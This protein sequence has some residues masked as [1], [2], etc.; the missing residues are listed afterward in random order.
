MIGP[1]FRYEMVASGRKKRYTALRVVIGLFLLFALTACYFAAIEASEYLSGGTGERGL[2]IAARSQLAVSFFGSFAWLTL[3]GVLAAT[4]ALAA[5]AI[6]TERERR[7]IEYL[8]ATDLSN[9]EIV[10]DKIMSRLMIIAQI[11][12]STLPLLAIFMLLGG[13]P[14]DLLLIHFCCLASTALCVA[15]LS[16]MV[17]TWSERAREAV[18]QAYGLLFGC[19]IAPGILMALD[20]A[21]IDRYLPFVS[22]WFFWPVIKVLLALNPIAVLTESMSGGALGVGLNLTNV[23]IMIAGHVGVSVGCLG[24]C[25]HA[26]RKVHL[27]QAGS[28]PAPE[29]SHGRKGRIRSPYARRP[30]LWKEMFADSSTPKKKR[31]RTRVGA[32]IVFLAVGSLVAWQFFSALVNPNRNAW[33]NYFE[34]TSILVAVM[35]P[36][37]MLILGSRAAGLITYEKEK[38]TWVS[39]LTTPM[40]AKE[41]ITAKLF[42]N[43]YAMRWAL[44]GLMVAPLLGMVLRPQFFLAPLLTALITGGA[45]ITATLIGLFY[46]LKVKNSVKAISL[47]MGTLVVLGGG[48]LPFV[49]LFAAIVSAGE[50]FMLMLAPCVPFL[51]AMSILMVTVTEIN[52]PPG[53]MIAAYIMGLAGYWVLSLILSSAL[54]EQFDEICERGDGDRSPRLAPIAGDQVVTSSSP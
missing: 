34:F 39:L 42:G 44:G 30:M 20:S 48:Y 53:E 17:S 6:A 47:T 5:G 27:R 16:L 35:G 12:L 36:L 43:L 24:L 22:A 51:Y 15:S 49:G 10:L 31:M 8:F 14:G 13:L 19:L 4:P 26:V 52:S 46:S 41:I 28:G 45:A 7:T 33:E 23:F 3:L 2:S 29:K 40:S 9:A 1:V 37:V 11:V 32:V 38:E 50:E 25:V 18:S 54:I 21:F